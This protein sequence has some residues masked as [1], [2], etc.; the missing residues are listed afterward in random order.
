MLWGGFIIVNPAV[1]KIGLGQM[2]EDHIESKI[3]DKELTTQEAA[4]FLNVSRPYLVSLLEKTK[5]GVLIGTLF[6]LFIIPLVYVLLKR[7]PLKIK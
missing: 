4:D 5:H 2:K 3:S 1:K 7:T 6:S